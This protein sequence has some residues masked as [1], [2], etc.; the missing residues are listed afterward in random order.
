MEESRIKA[1]V[2][3]HK[4]KIISSILNK[5]WMKRT[6]SGINFWVKTADPNQTIKNNL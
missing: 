5:I 4:S 2:Q 6:N 1:T 3:V